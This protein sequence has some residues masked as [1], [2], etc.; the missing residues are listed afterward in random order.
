M[1]FGGKY[2]ER[3][4]YN[5]LGAGTQYHR[6]DMNIPQVNWGAVPPVNRV[7]TDIFWSNPTGR[8]PKE[9]LE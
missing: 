4:G 8:A 9:V 7:G 3:V 2:T 1:G 6:Y 5:V